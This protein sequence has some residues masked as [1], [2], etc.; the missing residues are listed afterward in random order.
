[1]ETY[2]FPLS[3]SIDLTGIVTTWFI[4]HTNSEAFTC[5]D[6]YLSLLLPKKKYVGKQYIR[7]PD[8]FLII[9]SSRNKMCLLLPGEAWPCQ[10]Q[11][12]NEQNVS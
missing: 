12:D 3:D 2:F 11:R 10:N 4:Q 8:Y 9:I 1:M 5:K 6:L 7:K